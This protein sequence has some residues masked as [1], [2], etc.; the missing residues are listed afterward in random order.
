MTIAQLK[1]TLLCKVLLE[2]GLFGDGTAF[3]DLD[4]KEYICKMV[5]DAGFEAYGNEVMYNGLT[6]EQ[7]EA[8]IFIGPCF[9]QRLKHMVNDK[10]HSR[11]T[12]PMVILNRQPTEGRSKGGGLRLGEMEQNCLTSGGYSAFLR[13]RFYDASDKFSSYVCRKCGLIAAYND[14]YNIHLCKTCENKSDFS[15]VEIPY[16]FKLMSQELQTINVSMRLITE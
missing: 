16:A 1:E 10:V 2:L 3:G 14:K 7:I 8:N 5:Q 11:A 6:G 4:I 9:Y 12:G 13:E 15:Y